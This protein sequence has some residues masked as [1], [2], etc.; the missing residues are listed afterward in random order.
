MLRQ[1]DAERVKLDLNLAV[2]APQGSQDPNQLFRRIHPDVLISQCCSCE[3][4]LCVE[5]N[6]MGHLPKAPRPIE[7][8]FIESPLRC[9]EWAFFGSEVSPRHHLHWEMSGKFLTVFFEGLKPAFR[10]RL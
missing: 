8:S 3:L 7:S 4:I 10:A 9:G 1:P 6:R 5:M 2:V